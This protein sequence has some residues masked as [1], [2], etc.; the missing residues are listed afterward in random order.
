MPTPPCRD[1]LAG[2]PPILMVIIPVVIPD[3][4]EAP[5]LVELARADAAAVK[6]V[7]VEAVILD[8]QQPLA[9]RGAGRDDRGDPDQPA[10]R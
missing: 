9:G 10:A 6:V 5:I 1:G 3:P 4:V 7:E 8:Q 2:D